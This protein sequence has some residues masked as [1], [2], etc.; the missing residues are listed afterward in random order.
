M[1]WTVGGLVL[2]GTYLVTRSLWVPMALHF[3]SNFTNVV[4]FGIAGR[5]SLFP[6]R[7]RRAAGTGRPFGCST[8]WRSL[9]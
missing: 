2:G 7:G 3:A 8:A 9:S 4:V 6:F 1:S 5:F